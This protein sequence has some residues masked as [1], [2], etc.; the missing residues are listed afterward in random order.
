MKVLSVARVLDDHR[1]QRHEKSAHAVIICAPAA[2]AAQL[3]KSGESIRSVGMLVAQYRPLDQAYVDKDGLTE[4]LRVKSND[5]SDYTAVIRISADA[6]KSIHGAVG[7]REVPQKQS[8]RATIG[9]LY[10]VLVSPRPPFIVLCA[11]RRLIDNA[12][13]LFE[14]VKDVCVPLRFLRSSRLFDLQFVVPRPGVD[15]FHPDLQVVVLKQKYGG[16]R[17][18]QGSVVQNHCSKGGWYGACA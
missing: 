14:C 9:S 11:W 16:R 5:V 3:L 10:R 13:K 7:G 15:V 17:N 2:V 6:D 18:L 8:H 1:R 4:M 12:T